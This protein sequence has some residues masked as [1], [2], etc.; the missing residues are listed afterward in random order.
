MQDR[1][2]DVKRRIRASTS[3]AEIKMLKDILFI[4]ETLQ[5]VKD[6]VLRMGEKRT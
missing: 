6:E 4:L 5:E 2:D 3:T 1:I